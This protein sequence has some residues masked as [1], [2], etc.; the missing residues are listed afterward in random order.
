MLGSMA[1]RGDARGQDGGGCRW[2]LGLNVSCG[3]RFPSLP[4][5]CAVYGELVL[6]RKE[7]CT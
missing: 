1:E 7:L 3:V 5:R 2:P 4:V 6:S